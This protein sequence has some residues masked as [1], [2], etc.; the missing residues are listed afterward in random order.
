MNVCTNYDSWLACKSWFNFHLFRES[1]LCGIF[2]LLKI[3]DFEMEKSI[4]DRLSKME[5]LISSHEYRFGEITTD[6]K[7]MWKEITWIIKLISENIGNYKHYKT[8]ISISMKL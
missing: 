4:E 1:L 5:L 3:Y 2:I 7:N 8:N 6:I